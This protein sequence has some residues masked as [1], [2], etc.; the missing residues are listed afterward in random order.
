MSQGDKLTLADVKGSS[1]GPTI[2]AQLDEERASKSSLEAR[3]IGIITTS[4]VLAALLF[5]LVTFTRGSVNQEHLS[6]GATAG[7]AL[8]FGVGLF[9]RGSFRLGGQLAP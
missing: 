6:I 8:V 1:F 4:S 3:G 9:G 5:G 7:A 2:K